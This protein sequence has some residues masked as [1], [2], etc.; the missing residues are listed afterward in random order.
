MVGVSRPV[1]W[2]RPNNP[3]LF[4]ATTATT[5]RLP[6]LRTPRLRHPSQSHHQ[7]HTIPAVLRTSVI[8]CCLGQVPAVVSENCDQFGVVSNN[9]SHP[10][11]QQILS[12]K[13]WRENQKE[14]GENC[15]QDGSRSVQG[16]GLPYV[17]GSFCPSER[18]PAPEGT[19]T[20]T[21]CCCEHLSS[22]AL[23]IEM[24][25]SNTSGRERTHPV[26]FRSC[27]DTH[28]HFTLHKI[29]TP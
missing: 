1:R 16:E 29:H 20:L 8:Q 5:V 12:E 26:A 21:C 2:G 24:M 6:T 28:T 15:D 23:F 4:T 18:S 14:I 7:S 9:H 10:Q 17:W 22:I 25:S 11:A 19:R 27:R 3:R 13:S